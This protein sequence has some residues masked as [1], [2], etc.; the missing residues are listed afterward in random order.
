MLIPNSTKKKN[1]NQC[2]L[3]TLHGMLQMFG[4]FN[5]FMEIHK[6]KKNHYESDP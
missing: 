6:T 5:L 2:Y 4:F 1:I 3:A